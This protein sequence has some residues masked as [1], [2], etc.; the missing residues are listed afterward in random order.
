MRWLDGITAV[1]VNNN[2]RINLGLG[3]KDSQRHRLNDLHLRQPQGTA[4]GRGAAA[5]QPVKLQSRAQLSSRATAAKTDQTHTNK[6]GYANQVND[7]FLCMQSQ[8]GEIF[9]SK[10]YVRYT[11]IS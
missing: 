7:L 5:L 2:S 8:L 9:N 6:T 3:S 11:R 10:I 4:E 1:V